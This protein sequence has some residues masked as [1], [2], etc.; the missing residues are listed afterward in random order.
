[1]RPPL[2]GDLF[3][4]EFMYMLKKVALRDIR[5]IEKSQLF[6]LFENEASYEY[7]FVHPS[8]LSHVTDILCNI[9]NQNLI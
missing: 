8:V 9:F 4:S 3:I 2:L 1:M 5:K 6:A 7:F